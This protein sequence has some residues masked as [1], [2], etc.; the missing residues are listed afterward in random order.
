VD[1]TVDSANPTGAG[2]LYESVGFTAVR[3]V[4][5][6]VRDEELPGDAERGR[7]R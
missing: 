3:T 7:G 4:A 6:F 2:A 1:L 5:T